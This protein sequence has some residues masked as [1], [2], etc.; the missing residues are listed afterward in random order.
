MHKLF[1]SRP[2]LVVGI[3]TS[4]LLTA[5]G[6][7]IEADAPDAV[8]ST[9]VSTNTELLSFETFKTQTPR[10]EGENG[11]YVI[12]GDIRIT[13]EQ[14]L[15]DHWLRT[16]SSDS[17]LTVHTVKGKDA[18]WNDIQKMEL[19][20]C[21][22]NSFTT[23][24]KAQVVEAMRQASDLG[25]EKYGKVNFTY[26]PSQDSNC[27]ASNTKV[28]FPVL[29]VFRAP[30]T[31]AAFFPS[32]TKADRVLNIDSTAFSSTAGHP[33][34]DVLGH[35]LGHVLGFRHEHANQN[36]GMEFEDFNWRSLTTYDSASIMH[37]DFP[38]YGGTGSLTFTARDAEGVARYYGPAAG[39]PT[40]TGDT[41]KPWGNISKTNTYDFG[42]SSA[43]RQLD[44]LTVGG[45]TQLTV[46]MKGTGNADLYI[47][48]NS[49]STATL[50]DCR[51]AAA[52]SVETCAIEVPESATKAYVGVL[53]KS[54][55][56]V[57]VT[58]TYTKGVLKHQHFTGALVKST[59]IAQLASF[60][61]VPGSP[62]KVK[63][64][65]MFVLIRLDA[66][67]PTASNQHFFC[68]MDGE[69]WF[70]VPDGWTKVYVGVN[71]SAID[72]PD[73]TVDIDYV[74]P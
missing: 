15:R 19:T 45:G 59:D 26:V 46:E 54:D 43:I 38:P 32:D 25:W 37:Y 70:I 72:V 36:T 51:P 55:A 41:P 7:G 30:Y 17:A 68:N 20:Y 52:N 4:I 49:A 35:E 53:V 33:L 64:N 44:I 5:C 39:R 65:R 47:R 56:R 61:V 22:S 63:T 42:S 31:A 28:V 50:W 71:S 11:A 29:L 16:Y 1:T 14:A 10:E 3:I 18:R 40:P 21:V 2:P 23:T 12:E 13:S 74:A 60:S 67:P 66:I 9:S 8:K 69:C 34:K 62:F 73:A 24:T 57:T 58:Q 48:F 27:T 6:S